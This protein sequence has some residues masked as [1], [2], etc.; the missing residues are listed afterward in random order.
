ME[1]V[2]IIII[3]PILMLIN[4]LV[5][6]VGHNFYINQPNIEIYDILFSV[7]PRISRKYHIWIDISAI[8]LPSLVLLNGHGY[9]YMI[10]LMYILALR[11]IT[12]SVT[13]FPKDSKTEFT[14]VQNVLGIIRGHYDKVF[15]GHTSTVFLGALICY[16][17][18]L[19][20]N[21]ISIFLTLFTIIGLI[22]MRSHFTVDIILALVITY[23]T[24]FYLSSPLNK[25]DPMK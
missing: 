3:I 1:F 15:S 8:S 17:H 14:P 7:I 20:P 2:V 6:I 4:C 21:G 16:D 22:S 11:S 13:I 23:L 18:D 19:V 10:E 25:P 5:D 24:H 9:Q 12:T